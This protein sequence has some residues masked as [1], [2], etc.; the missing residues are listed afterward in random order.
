MKRQQ[1]DKN[2]LLDQLERYGYPLLR[3]AASVSAAEV[4]RKLLTQKDSRLLEGFPVV[5]VNAL[6]EAEPFAWENAKW[7]PSHEFSKQ[8]E[9]RLA[10]MLVLSYLLSKLFGLEAESARVL[11]L[12]AR[13]HRGKDLLSKF[14][15]PF[16]KSESV[17]LDGFQVSTE[18]LKNTFRLYVVHASQ[19]EESQKKQ[20]VLELELLLSELFT[21]RQKE[22]LKKRMQNKSMTKTE[23]EYFYRVVKKRLKALASDELHQMARRLLMK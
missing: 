17:K 18:R 5:L 16:L 9:Q 6:R 7:Q 2:E 10:G 12:V 4:L 1:T 11:K 20:H 19:S 15:E 21:P 14:S 23:R 8:A 3:P 22:L 13:C